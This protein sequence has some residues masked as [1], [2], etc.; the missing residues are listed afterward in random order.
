[1]SGE[2]TELVRRAIDA[3]HRRDLDAFLALM[4][5]EVEAQPLTAIMEGD[6]RGHE[7]VRR[8]WETLLDMLP[9]YTIE[10]VEVRDLGQVTVASLLARAHVPGSD[11][12]VE[13]RIW[14]VAESRNGKIVWWGNYRTEPEALDALGLRPKQGSRRPS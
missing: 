1:M 2:H 9:D 14:N 13:Q 11:A 6:Y 12:Q 7:G 8:W 4:D 3:L 5:P 10:A